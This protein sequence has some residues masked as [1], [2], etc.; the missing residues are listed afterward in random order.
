MDFNDVQNL[1]DLVKKEETGLNNDDFYLLR[2]ALYDIRWEADKARFPEHSE[3]SLDTIKTK[4]ETALQIIDKI[5]GL[6]GGE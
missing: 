6:G 5:D 1:N 3:T 4:V 2:R